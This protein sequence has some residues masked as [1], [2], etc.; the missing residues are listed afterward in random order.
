[1]IGIVR[2]KN[3]FVS[4]SAALIMARAPLAGSSKFYNELIADKKM[5]WRVNVACL[6]AADGM[7]V[8]NV[9]DLV[10]LLSL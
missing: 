8:P 2:T 1:M 5:N 6:S 10:N 7:R 4:S 3:E 9:L